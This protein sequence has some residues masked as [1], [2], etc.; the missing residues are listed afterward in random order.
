MRHVLVVILLVLSVA[1]TGSGTVGEI[2]GGWAVSC[3]ATP[4]AAGNTDGGVGSASVDAERTPTSV[5]ATDNDAV[6]TDTTAGVWRGNVVSSPVAGESVH[7]DV[8]GKL[9]F[10]VAD[11]TVDPVWFEETDTSTFAPS[12][13]GTGQIGNLNK[14]AVDTFND[15]VF[16]SSFG[17]AGIGRYVIVK[18][19]SAGNYITEFA[20]YGTGNGQFIGAVTVAVNPSDGSVYIGDG[21]NSRIQKFTTSGARTSYSYAAQV[22]TNGSGNGQFGFGLIAIALDSTGNVYAGDRGNARIQKFNSSLTYQAQVAVPGF[23]ASVPIYDLSMSPSDVLYASLVPVTETPGVIPI[24]TAGIVRTYNTSLVVLATVTPAIPVGVGAILYVTPDSSGFWAY[25]GYG[26]YV[27]KYDSTGQETNRWYSGY[28]VPENYNSGY[29]V[30]LGSSGRLVVGFRSSNDT[31]SAYLGMRVT[32]FNWSPVPLS[33]AILYYMLECDSALGGMTFSYDAAADPDVV[34]PAWSGDVWSHIKEILTAHN[35]DLYLDND[36]IRVDD[37]GA[38]TIELTNTSPIRTEPVNLFGGQELIMYATNATAGGGVMWSAA[39][40][41][42]RYQIDVGQRR[43][44]TVSTNNYPVQVNILVPTDN[45]PVLPGQYYVIDSTGTH[46]PAD[47]WLAA[48]ATVTPQLGAGV[49]QIDFTLQGP[50]GAISGYTGPFTFADGNSST[51]VGTLT[52]TGSGTFTNP[53]PVTFQTGANPT[54]TTQQVA[55]TIRNFAIDTLDRLYQRAPMAIDEVSGVAVSVSFT[56]PTVD[57]LGFGSTMGATFLY[58]DSRYR[59]TNA[60]FGALTTTITATRYVSIDMIDT[61]TTGLTIDQR[62]AI[63][64]GYSIDDRT[65]KPLALTL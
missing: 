12:G 20:A 9:N 25:W 10:L 6:L 60:T 48:G 58:N 17:V 38:R 15:A 62:D 36:T 14:V 2:M 8:L 23:N 18:Y 1:M 54:K 42:T 57:L 49:G 65:I 28:A 27:V 34:L 3:D 30:A 7:L 53:Q 26:N 39:D 29:P 37:A 47:M 22:G 59:I 52:V 16:V 32:A 31:N 4:L 56:V 35:L 51:S 63:W 43:T 46:V 55:R 24:G 11:R 45:L 61:A 64:D 41:N 21:G 44:V 50:S 33:D 13:T 19:D 40:S 5:F